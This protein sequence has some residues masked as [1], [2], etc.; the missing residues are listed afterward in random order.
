MWKEERPAEGLA[1]WRL[2]QAPWRQRAARMAASTASTASGGA[3]IAEI[4]AGAVAV[5]GGA[6]S[7]FNSPNGCSAID[8]MGV[9]PRSAAS[10]GTTGAGRGGGGQR[11]RLHQQQRRRIG[12]CNGRCRG[13][14][15]WQLQQKRRLWRWQRLQAH[16]SDSRH[17]LYHVDE[18]LLL[19]GDRLQGSGN[20]GQLFNHGAQHVMLLL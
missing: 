20:R 3:G 17:D 10:A 12:R 5:E 6:D 18:V 7:S 13:W 19:V 15:R 11:G 9:N 16:R 8:D 14:R 4:G 2:A 1:S